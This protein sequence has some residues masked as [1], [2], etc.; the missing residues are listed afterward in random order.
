M[1]DEPQASPFLREVR[2]HVCGDVAA[3]AELVADVTLK[4][5]WRFVFTGI[6]R[7]TGPSG[8]TPTDK[9]AARLTRAFSEP[10]SYG[11]VRTAWLY[12]EAGFCRDCEKPYCFEH[13]N[14]ST[15]GGGTCPAGHFKSLDPHWS[16][17]YGD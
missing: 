1:S 16:P 5:G 15:T 9:E 2:C 3:T 17:D 8:T 10:L 7:G 14:V 11:R 12:D 13:W 6:E 4:D